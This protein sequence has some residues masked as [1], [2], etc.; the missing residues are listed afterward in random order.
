MRKL[1]VMHVIGALPV[2]GVE[3]N[4]VRVLPRLNPEQFDVSVV[5][6][7]ELGDLA[8]E[9]EGVGIPVTLSYMKSRYNPFSLWKLAG[10]MKEREV[11][12]VHCHMRRA[13]T[14]GRIAAML[15]GVRVRIASERDMGL[16]KNRKH[17]LI[18]NLLGRFSSSV[19]CVTRG[20]AEHESVRSGLPL[21][22]F[23]VVYNGLELDGFSALPDRAESREKLGL[24][25]AGK[26]V[27]VVGRL[28]EIKNVDQIIK[29]FAQPEL[30][31]A[32]LLVVGDGRERE[33]LENLAREL[34]LAERVVFAGFRNDLPVFYSAID[35]S[36]LASSS[37][38]IANVQ[39]EAMA[40]GVP[41][42]STPVGMAA[43]ACVKGRDYIEV[44]R[45]EAS[46]LAGG[47]AE[48]LDDKR[49]EELKEAGLAAVQNFSIEAQVKRLEAYYLELAGA[50]GI[51]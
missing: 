26:V 39:M 28:H 13:N 50:C 33:M 37:E 25:G 15:A 10:L 32:T 21:E 16:G 41:L 8:P 38:G 30:A 11:D 18:D 35:V 36:V 9:M 14:S 12:I 19:M 20:V 49:G 43:E 51:E 29:A 6:I 17:Y 40:A 7:R 22:K 1:N 45:P 4:L 5:C 46:L 23:R 27:G 31:G 48:A 34:G 2:G 47:I 44:E 24:A 42:V 3:R